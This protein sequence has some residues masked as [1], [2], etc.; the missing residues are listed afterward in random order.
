MNPLLGGSGGGGG[1]GFH[2]LRVFLEPEAEPEGGAIS[3]PRR[4]S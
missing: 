3:L 4:A 1:A 2:R